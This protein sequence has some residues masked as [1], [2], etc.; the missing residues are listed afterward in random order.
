MRCSTLA[1]PHVFVAPKASVDTVA[2]PSE[3]FHKRNPV[4]SRNRVSR[5]HAVF[6]TVGE[7]GAKPARRGSVTPDLSRRVTDP[8]GATIRQQHH[9]LRAHH[10][11]A[12]RPARSRFRACREQ[13]RARPGRSTRPPA[14]R[15]SVTPDSK[16]EMA[17]DAQA[18]PRRSGLCVSCRELSLSVKR[19]SSIH[20]RISYGPTMRPSTTGPTGEL[21]AT[22]PMATSS[23]SSPGCRTFVP[24]ANT[25]YSSPP[26]YMKSLVT[27]RKAFPPFRF[28]QLQGQ[29]RFLAPWPSRLA[30]LITASRP[31]SSAL[32]R[33]CCPRR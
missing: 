5:V 19:P 16:P 1:A 31:G 24:C 20:S 27:K 17:T 4:S 21:A 8:A 29:G 10:G 25:V 11:G 13:G 32:L 7:I 28:G 12:P 26:V 2:E 22:Y 6:D 30:V 23:K 33:R 18:A 15:G 9:V 3:R 14:C